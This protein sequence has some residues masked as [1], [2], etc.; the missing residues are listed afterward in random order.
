MSL[1]L[2]DNG[3]TVK[4]MPA[5]RGGNGAR[6]FD[7]AEFVFAEA[8]PVGAVVFCLP[9]VGFQIRQQVIIVRHSLQP[10]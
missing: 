3:Q 6:L 7:L 5:A 9:R 2:S 4:N 1:N 8:F 10:P